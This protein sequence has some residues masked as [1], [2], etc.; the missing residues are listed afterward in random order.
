MTAREYLGQYGEAE[1]RAD[2]LFREYM[3][4]KEKI[5]SIRSPLG[6][7]GTPPSGE[8]GKPTEARAMRLAERAIRYKEAAA[9]AMQIRQEVFDVIMKVPGECGSVLYERYINLKFWRVIADEMGYT[10][11]HTHN[12]ER[13]GL[14]K[15]QEITK[16]CT[17]FH[18]DM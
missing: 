9:D 3:E 7:D 8:P 12:L 6:G 10:V 1:R 4:E 13:R 17:L 16:E 15:I 18:T 14:E 5:D 2:R 11:R